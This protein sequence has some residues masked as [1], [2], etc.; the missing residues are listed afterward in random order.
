MKLGKG[1]PVELVPTSGKAAPLDAFLWGYEHIQ[2]E[3]DPVQ[4]PRQT[5][6]MS[7]G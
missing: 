4:D 3:R 2:L 7:L 6:E 1:E 5:V